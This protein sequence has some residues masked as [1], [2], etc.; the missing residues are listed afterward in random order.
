MADNTPTSALRTKLALVLVSKAWR[1]LAVQ[2]LYKHVAIR[3][4]M[5][6]LA[7]LKSLE[8]SRSS[9]F[10]LQ[11]ADYA[12]WIRH[13]EVFTFSRGSNDITHLQ[14]IYKILMRCTNLQI[15]SGWWTRPLPHAFLDAVAQQLGPVISGLYWNDMDVSY[16]GITMEAS[17]KFICSFQSLSVLDLRHITEAESG[18]LVAESCPTLP[19]LKHIVLSTRKESLVMATA[20][21][22]PSLRDL[23]M[24]ASLYRTKTD[25]LMKLFL[26][27]NGASLTSVDLKLSLK[28]GQLESDITRLQP[29]LS[30]DVS[31]DLFLDPQNCPFLE[32]FAFPARAS[33]ITV[34][35]PC[36]RR[37]GIRGAH[38]EGLDV[39]KPSSLREHLMSI[40][41]KK[42]PNLQVIMMID[43]VAEAQGDYD[44]LKKFFV[45]WNDRFS[46]MDVEFLDGAAMQYFSNEPNKKEEHAV[47]PSHSPDV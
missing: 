6:A 35:S 39:D 41:V 32:G 42:F 18:S 12:Q 28:A 25:G 17:L 43:F 26:Q 7:I 8:D 29:D 34:S 44:T 45:R 27:A 1:C 46:E 31:P 4:P 47:D 3:S 20:L 13:I 40:D 5:R 24:E 11:P 38:R 15:F 9:N 21:R 16:R 30:C 22:L 33:E 10:P 2:I 14:T 37:I 23:V 36:L 19:R